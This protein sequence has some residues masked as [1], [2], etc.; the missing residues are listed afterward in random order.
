MN[1]L[2]S[3]ARDLVERKLWPVAAL[4]VLALVAVPIVFLRPADGGNAANVIA[5]PAANAAPTSTAAAAKKDKPPS[6][7]SLLGSDKEPKVK[8]STSGPLNDPFKPPASAKQPSTGST[9]A[10]SSPAPASLPSTTSTPAATPFAPSTP[11]PAASTTTGPTAPSTTLGPVVT[12]PAPAAAGS[13]H[14]LVADIRFGLADDAPVSA[15]VAR[16]QP[17]PTK[18][19]PLAV[20]L[21]ITGDK[22][23]AAF[24]VTPAATLDGSPDCRPAPSLCRVLVLRKNQLTHLTVQTSKG[25]RVFSLQLVAIRSEDAGS[26]A[27]AQAARERESHAGSCILHA[28]GAYDFDATQGTLGINTDKTDCVYQDPQPA[29][30]LPALK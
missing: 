24:L 19:W 20:F 6:L 3:V 5:P 9:P 26:A 11:V 1:P 16:L 14:K 15:D 27:A 25:D 7:A 29:N 21:G 13:T 8:L 4:L 12:A 30:S 23:R 17:F 28:I 2:R 22:G 18:N 10:V